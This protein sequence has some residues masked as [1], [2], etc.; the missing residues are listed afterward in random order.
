LTAGYAP[1]TIGRVF[2]VKAVDDFFLPERLRRTCPSVPAAAAAG[3]W[4][5]GARA[6]IPGTPPADPHHG[7]HGR[8]SRARA[9]GNGINGRESRMGRLARVISAAVVRLATQVGRAA[10]WQLFRRPSDCFCT[11][12]RMAEHAVPPFLSIGRNPRVCPRGRGNHPRL[13]GLRLCIEEHPL[14]IASLPMA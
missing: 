12:L 1:P 10:E 2:M 3:A 14:R 7:R 6:R 5:A 4:W 11:Y 9:G 8:S 13:Q